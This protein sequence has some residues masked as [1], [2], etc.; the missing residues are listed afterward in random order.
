VHCMVRNTHCPASFAVG[1]RD[2]LL[3]LWD[4]NNQKLTWQA[5]NLPNDELD[6][7]IPIWDTDVEFLSYLNTHSLATC[8]AYSDIREYDLRS[9]AKPVLSTKLFGDSENK[10]DI[11]QQRE[12]YLAKIIQSSVNPQHL[13]VVTQ[14][15]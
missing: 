6:L 9:Q 15:G 4:V 2:T 13:F 12:I 14:E 3:Q 5:K 7:K 11:F 1:S 8:T 10:K